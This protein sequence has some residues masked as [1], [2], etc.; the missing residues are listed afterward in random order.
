MRYLFTFAVIAQLLPQ[1]V[2]AQG[3][4]GS[5]SP[6]SAYGLGDLLGSTQVSQALMGGVGAG[7]VDPFSVN[8]ANPASY[9]GLRIP[10]FETGLATRAIR[11]DLDE[12]TAH[13][14][15]TDI[16][17]LTL[18]VPV[19]PGSILDGNSQPANRWGFALGIMP[20][21]RVGYSIDDTLASGASDVRFQYHG[22][23]GLNR[24]FLGAG[25][26]L[27]QNNDTIHRGTRISAGA[28]FNYVFGRTEESRTTYFPVATNSYNVRV[29]EQ[30]IIRSPTVNVGMQLSGDAVSAARNE[31]RIQRR[32]EAE[33]A[34]GRQPPLRIAEPL[35]YTLGLT[36][37]LPA[38]LAADR[39]A[40]VHTFVVGTTGL[41]LPYDTISFQDAARGSVEL[42]ALLGAGFSLYNSRWT[43]ALE[44]RRRDW[45]QFVVRVDDHEFRSELGEQ[46]VYALGGS[47]RP[48]G[49]RSGTI[50]QRSIY[51]AGLR[52]MEDYRIVAGRQLQ[53]FGMSFGMALPVMANTTRS[54]LS[55]GV[56]LGERGATGEGMLRERFTTVFVGVTITP[57]VR[58][59][60]FKKRRLE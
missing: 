26:T 4:Q 54:R 25:L 38:S 19:G 43:I 24:A 46:A 12:S 15:R 6:Y 40:L 49:D 56:E 33:V 60:W 30:L 37:E 36:A 1:M 53:E 27:W 45:S 52:Y 58:E 17:G 35:R 14:R 32:R 55:F 59:Q 23:G 21:S 22:D 57:D 50:W 9:V 51:R 42:P 29:S 7:L 34:A 31:G 39:T 8:H 47:F 44:H 2:R 5:G 10:V 13:G 18:G 11:Q 41:E 28:N 20:L 16:L 48:A 3:Q